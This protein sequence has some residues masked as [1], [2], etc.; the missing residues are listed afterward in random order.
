MKTRRTEAPTT[1][2]PAPCSAFERNVTKIVPRYGRPVSLTSENHV[3][4]W[5]LCDH[6]PMLSDPKGPLYSLSP[7]WTLVGWCKAPFPSS[8]EYNDALVMEYDP[9]EGD[10]SDREFG[11]YWIH[12]RLERMTFKQNAEVKS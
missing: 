9:R 5:P 7:G 12:C 4:I 10:E 6:R 3:G 11:I 8:R 1:S 2:V